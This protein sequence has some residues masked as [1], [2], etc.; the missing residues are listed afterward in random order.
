MR[1]MYVVGDPPL[2][3]TRVNE[4]IGGLYTA[5][6]NGLANKGRIGTSMH[7]AQTILTTP[8]PIA[9]VDPGAVIDALKPAKLSIDGFKAFNPL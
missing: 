9:C 7:T 2:A 6:L 5:Y 8:E 4:A 3:M 1:F